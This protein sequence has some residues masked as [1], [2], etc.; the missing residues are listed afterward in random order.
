VKAAK[1]DEQPTDPSVT[2]WQGT[3]GTIIPEA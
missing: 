1:D 2:T 3:I